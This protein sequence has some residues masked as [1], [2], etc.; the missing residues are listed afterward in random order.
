M[1]P[2]CFTVKHLKR[3]KGNK[4]SCHH[5]FSMSVSSSRE[6]YIMTKFITHTYKYFNY[7]KHWSEKK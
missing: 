5:H 7:R 4:C 3:S 6:Y 1:K 2:G